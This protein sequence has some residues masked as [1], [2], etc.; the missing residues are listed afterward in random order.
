[1]K[2]A[3]DDARCCRRACPM[4]RRLLPPP[5]R[6]TGSSSVALMPMNAQPKLEQTRHLVRHPTLL[7]FPAHGSCHQA[8]AGLQKCGTASPRTH[9]TSAP[10]PPSTHLHPLTHAMP[11]AAGSGGRTAR[12]AAGGAAAPG[13]FRFSFPPTMAPYDWGLAAMATMRQ[14]R[15]CR[16]RRQRSRQWRGARTRRLLQCSTRNVDTPNEGAIGSHTARCTCLIPA[17]ASGS[18]RWP[19]LLAVGVSGRRLTTPR[20]LREAGR[21]TKVGRLLWRHACD[22]GGRDAMRRAH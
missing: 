8:D 10:L 14:T 22:L 20:S 2:I 12:E 17:L 21:S 7:S 15:S 13:R 3:F 9:H 18:E 16:L 11:V 19:I 1:M 6:G 5:R 4:E